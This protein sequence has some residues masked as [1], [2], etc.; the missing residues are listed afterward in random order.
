MPSDVNQAI[1]YQIVI[2]EFKFRIYAMLNA[3]TRIDVY[4]IGTV[5]V[6]FIEHFVFDAIY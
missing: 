5:S 6:Y 1:C 4:F 3:Y 2:D